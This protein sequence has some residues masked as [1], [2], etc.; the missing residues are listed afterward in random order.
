MSKQNNGRSDKPDRKL[1]KLNKQQCSRRNSTKNQR[2]EKEA[3]DTVLSESNPYSWYAKNAQFTSDAGRVGFAKPLG[4]LLQ[5]GAT[6]VFVNPGV[7]RLTFTPTVGYSEN[8]Q[9]AV[10][11]AAGEFYTYI[12][13][14]M[15]VSGN[16]EA[17]DLMIYFMAL[18]SAY[19]FY[20]MMRRAYDVAQL[21][22]PMNKYY[23]RTLLQYMGF[24]PSIANDLSAFRSYINKYALSLS[25]YAIPN[26]FTISDRHMW[27][28]SGLYLDS[29]TTRAQT[30]LFCPMILW[31]YNNTAQTGSEL[32]PVA[33]QNA[34]TAITMHDL[35]TTI[36]F[37][38]NLLNAITNDEDVLEMSGDIYRAYGEGN[39]RKLG[40]VVDNERLIPIY[41]KTVLSQIENCSILGDLDVTSAR[42]YQDPSINSGA[43]ISEYHFLGRTVKTN[44]GGM[45]MSPAF[46]MAGKFIN[47]HNDNPSPEEVI[48]ATRLACAFT[49]P[50]TLSSQSYL[51]PN[52]MP[53]DV[54]NRIWIGLFNA[55]GSGALSTLSQPTSEIRYASGTASSQLLTSLQFMA[56]QDS[57]D[58]SPMLYLYDVTGPETPAVGDE[59]NLV[60]VIADVDNFDYITASRLQDMHDAAMYSLFDVPKVAKM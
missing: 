12:R 27:M 56:L 1:A 33:W 26:G 28:C 16:Y 34:G 55:N 13:S 47:L 45:Y 46:Q 21:Y 19:M 11:R 8:L 44:S 59:Y 32:K 37:G 39:L 52:I 10:N 36:T 6:D 49:T 25:R 58:W 60:H 15:R 50:Q 18:D 24:D 9:S 57:F 14:V 4:A 51:Q 2:R 35:A 22:T 53:A 40:E 38:E 41:D 54:I 23:P 31:Q 48:E 7:M 30:Y 43:I 3:V 42:I 5:G 17:A 29:E 20:A